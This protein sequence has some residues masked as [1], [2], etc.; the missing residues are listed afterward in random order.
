M[1]QF[2]YTFV[3]IVLYAI[4][5]GKY[6][7]LEGRFSNHVFKNWSKVICHKPLKFI[8]PRTENEIVEIIKKYDRIRVVGAGHNE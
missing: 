4:S 7:F 1:K 5:F 6:T 8:S 2:I 3:N